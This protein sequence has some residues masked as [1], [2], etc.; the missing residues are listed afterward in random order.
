MAL[1]KLTTI[2]DRVRMSR[3]WAAS[4][5][6]TRSAL[7]PSMKATFPRVVLH[8]KRAYGRDVGIPTCRPPATCRKEARVQGAQSSFLTASHGPVG[9]HESF[10]WSHHLKDFAE[11]AETWLLKSVRV[12]SD[13]R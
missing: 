1:G 2:S 8:G 12:P 3:S 13:L 7:T 5:R 11:H 4:R 9:Q 10:P 6:P